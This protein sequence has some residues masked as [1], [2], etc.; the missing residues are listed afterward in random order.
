MTMDLLREGA[1]TLGLS[2]SPK[3]LEMFQVY[4]Q[5]LT[6]WNQRFNLTAITG[7]KEVQTKHFLDSL[8]CLLALPRNDHSPL[9]NQVPL[10]LHSRH[11]WCLDV[12]SGAGFPGLPLKILIPE[13]KLTLIEATKKKVIF[14]EHMIHLL[15]LEKVEAIHTRAEEIGHVPEHRE[16]YDIVLA[17][18]VAHLTILCEYCLPLCHLGGRMIALKGKD[19]REEAGA[20]QKALDVLGGSLLEVKPI[21][22]PGLEEHHLVVVDKVAKTPKRYPRRPGVPSKRPLC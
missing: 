19:A 22:L 10:Q 21:H 8:S 13:M 14:L 20:S 9:P 12:G 3:H 6:T 18:A 2:L 7:Y 4:Y 16:Q 17:R 11:L 5:E 15:D 1:R